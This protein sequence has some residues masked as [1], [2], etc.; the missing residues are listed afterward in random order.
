M[1][2][3]ILLL[4]CSTFLGWA[5]TQERQLVWEENFNGTSLDLNVWNIELGDGCPNNCKWGNN[6]LQVYTDKNFK[7]RNGKLVITAQKEGEGYTSARL[8]T[9]GK[10]EFQYGKMEIRAK[11]PTA[12]GVWPAVWMLGSN[13]ETVGW[14]K[15]GEIDILEYVSREPH[16]VFT[17]LHTQDSH[18]ITINTKKTTLPNIEKGY[19]LYTAEWDKDKIAFFIDNRLV[20]T[21]QPE[22]KNEAIWPFDQPFYFLVNLAVGGNFGGKE[23]KDMDFPDNFYIDYIKVYQ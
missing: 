22:V 20:Y 3:Y 7:V 18:G 6:E 1:K 11:L 21:F 5:Q 17:S 9:Q 4:C 10:K 16:V 8:T 2:K 14:P 15:C 23:V 13:I 12:L 19:H